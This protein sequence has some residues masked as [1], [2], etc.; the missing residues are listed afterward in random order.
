M[1]NPSRLV[2][3]GVTALAMFSGAYSAIGYGLVVAPG[4]HSITIPIMSLD[5]IWSI[6]PSLQPVHVS[7]W[8]LT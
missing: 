1:K 3:F 7:D 2:K 6:K 5:L 8:C 4:T